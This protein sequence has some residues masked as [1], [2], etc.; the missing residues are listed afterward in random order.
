MRNPKNTETSRNNE[1]AGAADLSVPRPVTP[2]ASSGTVGTKSPPRTPPPHD[3]PVPSPP[4][5]SG[6][7]GGNFV[8]YVRRGQSLKVPVTLNHHVKSRPFL[9]AVIQ[10][11]HSLPPIRIGTLLQY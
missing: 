5:P 8:P 2:D 7:R 6:V 9:S 11:H 3:P 1:P 10:K 4:V